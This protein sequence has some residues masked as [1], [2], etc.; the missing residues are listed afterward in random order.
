M[1][2][3]ITQNSIK[4]SQITYT[5]LYSMPSGTLLK[6][7]TN[8]TLGHVLELVKAN[9]NEIDLVLAAGDIAQDESGKAYANFLEIIASLNSPFRWIPGNYDNAAVMNRLAEGT[10]AS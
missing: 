9:E 5:H 1:T 4:I 2:S 6:M 8:E 3:L 10:G 7:N